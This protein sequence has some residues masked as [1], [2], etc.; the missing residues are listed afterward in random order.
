[1]QKRDIASCFCKGFLK[2]SVFR[3]IV[4]I[5]SRWSLSF[6]RLYTMDSYHTWIVRRIY[7]DTVQRAGLDVS[8]MKINLYKVIR[9]RRSGENS[10]N[11][12]K[13][14][15]VGASSSKAGGKRWIVI[16]NSRLI[17]WFIISFGPYY[18]C[19]AYYSGS[20]PYLPP[21]RVMNVIQF[22]SYNSTS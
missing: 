11:L 7:I 16:E 22:M 17:S 5:K 2:H 12:K 21:F 6:D 3:G 10:K 14:T 1:M 9:K 18:S 20:C 13:I 4:W 8:K 15:T 19:D